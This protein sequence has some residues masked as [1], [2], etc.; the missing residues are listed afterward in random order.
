MKTKQKT[1]KKKKKKK[2]KKD[3]GLFHYGQ[4]KGQVSL[5]WSR[6]KGEKVVTSE[7]SLR[8]YKKGYSRRVGRN[9]RIQKGMIL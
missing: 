9:L 4:I 5:G 8:L 7:I 6:K 3:Y 2:K 1:K